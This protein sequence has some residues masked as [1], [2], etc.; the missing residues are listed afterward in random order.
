[1][2]RLRERLYGAPTTAIALLAL[3]LAMGGAAYA[4][5]KAAKPLTKAQIIALI[6]ANAGT[7]PEGKQGPEGKAGSNGA[8]GTSGTNGASVKGTQF[9]DSEGGCTEGGVKFETAEGTVYACNGKKGS[10]GTAARPRSAPSSQ[11]PKKKPAR[12]PTNPAT[13]REALN[14]ASSEVAPNL[15]LQRQ[16]RQ[17]GHHRLHQDPARRR[18]RDR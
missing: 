17:A 12:L 5:K 2:S 13:S 14:S 8:N 1:M 11:P 4:A 10:N 18:N 7:G 16:G 3:V 15:R 6:K 9:A